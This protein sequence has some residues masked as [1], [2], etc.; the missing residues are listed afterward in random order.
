M[1]R[2]HCRC[3]YCD[4]RRVLSK[5]P[6]EYE[7]TPKCRVC[8]YRYIFI[9]DGKRKP[10]NASAGEGVRESIYRVDGWMNR[11]DTRAMGCM[12]SGYAWGG[13][14]SGAMHRRGSLKCWFRAD[15]TPREYG[16]ADYYIDPDQQRMDFE[17]G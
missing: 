5:H 3:R 9:K 15:G 16:D 17:H 12:C 10:Q 1:S 8:G 7:I 13:N 11:R 6:D 2:I 4:T 14:M